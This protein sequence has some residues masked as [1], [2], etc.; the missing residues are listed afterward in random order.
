[1]SPVERLIREKLGPVGYALVKTFLRGIKIEFDTEQ[2]EVRITK[3][4][5]TQAI[6]FDEIRHFLADFSQ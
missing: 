1:M 3:D 2:K 6:D 5:K 4:G